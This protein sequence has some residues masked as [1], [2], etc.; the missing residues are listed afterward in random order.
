MIMSWRKPDGRSNL[1]LPVGYLWYSLGSGGETILGSSR[2]G[3]YMY[4]YVGGPDDGK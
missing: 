3:M 1:Y 2:R 4:L